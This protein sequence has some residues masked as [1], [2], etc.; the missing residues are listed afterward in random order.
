MDYTARLSIAQEL[1][2]HR[3]ALSIMVAD[4]EGGHCDIRHLLVAN[5]MSNASDDCCQF[6]KLKDVTFVHGV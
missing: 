3:L 6:C 4:V 2:G 1:G 5:A